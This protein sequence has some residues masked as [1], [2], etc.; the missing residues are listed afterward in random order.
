[1]SRQTPILLDT[2]NNKRKKASLEKMAENM[3]GK[4]ALLQAWEGRE[5]ADPDYIGDLK[6][7]IRTYRQLDLQGTRRSFRRNK[8]ITQ[9]EREGNYIL[10]EVAILEKPTKKEV[11]ENG[12]TEKLVFGPKAVVANDPKARPLPQCW[13]AERS[14]WTGRG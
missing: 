6:A 13:T 10:Y 7:K 14:K 4:L 11:E 8:H 9:K 5:D 1:M 3:D 12:A 2:L